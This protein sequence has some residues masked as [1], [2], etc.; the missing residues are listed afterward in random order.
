MNREQRRKQAKEERHNLNSKR[1]FR[2][3]GI[4]KVPI[5]KIIH[6]DNLKEC[7][8]ELLELI[9]KTYD[10]TLKNDASKH[11]IDESIS[12]LDS[13]CALRFDITPSDDKKLVR[14]T[15]HFVSDCVNMFIGLYSK[16]D[17]EQTLQKLFD[18]ANV[19]GQTEIL[20]N[21]PQHEDIAPMYGG[22]LKLPSSKRVNDLYAECVV[23][24]ANDLVHELYNTKYA[25]VSGDEVQIFEVLLFIS[26]K[27][28]QL[29]P[30]T[31]AA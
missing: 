28:M 7:D 22:V 13:L 10:W 27:T 18:E 21:V 2:I 3:G 6:D 25:D 15:M 31:D 14:D 4:Q 5:D 23:R 16:H 20:L 12:Y 8:P 1:N 26:K 24:H 19:K 11:I 9:C 17:N 29:L 30:E